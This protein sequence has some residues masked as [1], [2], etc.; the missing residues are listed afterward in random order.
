MARRSVMRRLERVLLGFVMAIA[1][2]IIERRVIR[3]IKKKGG[4][5]PRPVETNLADEI[6]SE[7]H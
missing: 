4:E 7:L 3:A 6:S 1:A 2:F 5:A